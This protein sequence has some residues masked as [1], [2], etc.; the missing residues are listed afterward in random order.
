[1]K[2]YVLVSQDERRVEVY[3]LGEGGTWSCENSG[4]GRVTV[5]GATIAVNDVYE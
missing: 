1:M 4:G 5:H 3:R 2:E